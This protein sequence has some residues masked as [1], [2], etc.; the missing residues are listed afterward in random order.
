MK[1]CV[2]SFALMLVM[3]G[4]SVCVLR[5][6]PESPAGQADTAAEEELSEAQKWYRG[7]I[8]HYLRGNWE[9]LEK[10]VVKFRTHRRELTR[11]ERKKA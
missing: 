11:D 6:G 3:L 1:R 4:A 10:Q 7:L 8:E 9:E 2:H 5:A